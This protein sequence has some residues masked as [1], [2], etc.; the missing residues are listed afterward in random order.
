MR[1]IERIEVANDTLKTFDKGYY[2]Y[3]NQK[4]HIPYRIDFCAH[5]EFFTSEELATLVSEQK[6]DKS[7][8]T[9]ISVC[10]KTTMEVG[11]VFAKSGNGRD[12]NVNNVACLNFASATNP[13]GGFL[14]GAQAQEECLARSS[15]FYVSLNIFKNE[16][17]NYHRNLASALYSDRMIYSPYVP[18]FKDDKGRYLEQPYFMDVLTSPAPNAS[19]MLKYNLQGQ[20]AMREQTMM[21]RIDKMLGLFY[22]KGAKI[23]ILGAWGCGAFKNSPTDVARYFAHYLLNNGKYANAFEQI[24]FAVYDPSSTQENIRAFEDMFQE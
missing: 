22:A 16:M 10:N 12:G 3:D 5:T 1:R 21:A 14:S 17:Y 11:E 4:V 24:V 13:G 6:I 7:K 19:S 15:G 20:L 18:F 23:L 2:W 8:N 9:K